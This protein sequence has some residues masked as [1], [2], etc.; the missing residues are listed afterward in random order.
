MVCK[1]PLRLAAVGVK[2]QTKPGANWPDSFKSQKG[3]DLKKGGIMLLTGIDDVVNDAVDGVSPVSEHVVNQEPEPDRKPEA[4]HS[5]KPI[6]GKT[7]KFGR[8]FDDKIH[9]SNPNGTPR[10][11]RKDGYI[12]IKPGTWERVGGKGQPKS[13]IGDI[14]GRSSVSHDQGGGADRGGPPLMSPEQAG[15]IAANMTFTFGMAIGG[16]EW[17]PIKDESL[18]VDEAAFMT[19]A[20]TEY[21]K[22]IG[23]KDIP[24]GWLLVLAL[25]S[26]ALPRLTMPKTQ[27]RFGKLVSWIKHKLRRSK[28]G[29]R[30]NTGHDGE[31]QDDTSQ[32]TGAKSE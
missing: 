5:G 19:L 15:M 17:K 6:K 22:S 27:N 31:R 18:G 1:N 8:A 14:P 16:D 7:D 25:G 28:S 11:N 32:E 12:S 29:A 20:Y 30:A 24:P 23:V 26:Y 3:P 9:V 2:N 4:D 21:F 13:K 10:I